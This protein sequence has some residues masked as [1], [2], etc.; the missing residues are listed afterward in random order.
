M[1][2]WEPY[3]PE[4]KPKGFALFWVDDGVAEYAV[5]G[6]VQSLPPEDE[7][8]IWDDNDFGYALESEI[9]FW[10]PCARPVKH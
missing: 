10:K 5:Y 4:N 7:P 9:A 1:S 2:E 6:I 3:L 8:R